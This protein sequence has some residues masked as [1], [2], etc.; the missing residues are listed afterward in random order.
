[1]MEFL[2]GHIKEN[3]C[4]DIETLQFDLD[5]WLEGYN[6]DRTRPGEK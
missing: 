5:L 1:M 2:S 6:H 3:I 4:Q